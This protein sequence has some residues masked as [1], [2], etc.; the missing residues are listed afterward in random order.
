VIRL[1][2]D[3]DAPEGSTST[4]LIDLV[5]GRVTLDG[6]DFLIEG[7]DPQ[8]A[9]RAEDAELLVRRCTFRRPPGSAVASGSRPAAIVAKATSRPASGPAADRGVSL[10]LDS[11]EFEGGQ[12]AV[13]ASGPVEVNIRD[14]TFGPAKADQATIWAENSSRTPARRR[15]G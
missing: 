2:R 6:I 8:A 1:A 11:S 13:S 5:G 10:W 14:C 15:S 7:D 4:A 9:I 12:V 3:P